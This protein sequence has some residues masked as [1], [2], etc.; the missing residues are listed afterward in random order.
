MRIRWTIAT[1]LIALLLT[2]SPVLAFQENQTQIENMVRKQDAVLKTEVF[3][4]GALEGIDDSRIAVTA[5]K[6]TDLSTQENR[7]GLAA[8]I[9]SPREK[10]FQQVFIDSAELE[11]LIK[12]VDQIW[13]NKIKAAPN[14]GVQ[15]S[16]MTNG[17]FGVSFI[18]L[19]VPRGD[20]D[21]EVRFVTVSAGGFNGMD[22]SFQFDDID[23]YEDLDGTA[24][25]FKLESLRDIRELLVEGKTALDS[26]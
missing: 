5:V 16:Y 14:K 17:R 21:E 7:T 19:Q 10:S 6:V 12:A 25:F 1:C 13:N 15:L 20:S 24:S 2:V 8:L 9:V 23:D 4:V 11:N 26:I 22:S 3:E 18:E